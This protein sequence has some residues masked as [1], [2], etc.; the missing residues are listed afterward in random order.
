MD[1]LLD[2]KL[3]PPRGQSARAAVAVVS[4]VEM[5]GTDFVLEAD[6]HVEQGRVAHPVDTMK[7]L[8]KLSGL[9]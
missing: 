2:F 3:G 1:S 6:E 7:K 5:N 8:I 9:V 4:Q